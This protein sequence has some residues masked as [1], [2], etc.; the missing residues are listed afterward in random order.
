V[1]G[2]YRLTAPLGAGAFAS[3]WLAVDERLEREVAVKIIPKSRVIS[4]RF[5]REAWAAAR[6]SHPAIV[7]LY[8]AVAEEDA[9]YLVSELVKGFTLEEALGAGRLSDQD[10]VAV[11]V[12]LCDAL[13]YAHSEGIIHRDV[14]PSNILIP[15]R[16]PA[17]TPPA[18]LTDFGVA[19]STGG[20][21]LTATGDVIGTAAYMAPE[22]AAGRTA[23]AAADLYSLALVLYEGLTGV[24]PLATATAAQRTTRLGLYLPP[25]RRQRRE[26]PR[27]LGHGIDLALRPRPGERGTVGELREALELALPAMSDRPGVVGA[28]WR[29]TAP[30]RPSDSSRAGSQYTPTSAT[31][32]ASPAVA[33][34]TR[35][36]SLR[37][38]PTVAPEKPNTRAREPSSVPRSTAKA[39]RSSSVSL[40]LPARASAAALGAAL[41]GWLA[42]HALAPAPLAP[43]V[44][45]LAAAGVLLA[46]PRVGY[47]IVAAG[48]TILAAIGGHSGDAL[49]LGV[50][51]LAPVFA[52][53]YAEP[54]WLL[55]AGAPLLGAIGLG[56]AW[57]AMAA[58]ADTVRARAALGLVGWL[59]LAVATPL[60]GASLYLVAPGGEPPLSLWSSSPYE[61][62]HQVL[63]GLLSSGALAPAV[64]WALAAAVLPLLVGKKSLLLDAGRVA[65]WAVMLV[66]CTQAAIAVTYFGVGH[67]TLHGAVLGAV[68]AAAVA[69]APSVLTAWRKMHSGYVEP[70]LP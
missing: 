62:A 53:P 14:K 51:A 1:L 29:P 32:Q 48:L 18:K 42:A 63:G 19:R 47:L 57:P 15:E 60:T 4:A 20:D 10:I 36:L 64:V 68:G 6:L 70:G 49:V 59:W 58:R 22:Q 12:A 39:D 23:A 43:A 50:A 61:A 13:A 56:G 3:V 30:W 26:L 25:L 40:P 65:V 54:P 67:A 2:R 46:F 34:V 31:R 21:S 33:A 27:E 8:E 37:G 55:A 5:E 41:T 38:T 16:P 11:G 17:A 35:L 45:A 44:A 28:P 66:I 24:N 69:L 9:A 7:T 52:S